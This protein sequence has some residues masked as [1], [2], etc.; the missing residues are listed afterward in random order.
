MYGIK[1]VQLF[2]LSPENIFDPWTLQNP[3]VEFVVFMPQK[4]METQWCSL[5]LP[6]LFF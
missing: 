1:H 2:H 4:I 3:R 5:N 6:N